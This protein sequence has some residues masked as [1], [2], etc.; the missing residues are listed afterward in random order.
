MINDAFERMKQREQMALDRKLKLQQE[1]ES[2]FEK[3]HQKSK[4]IKGSKLILETKEEQTGFS[5]S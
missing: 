1:A 3:E 5:F 4:M 2:N